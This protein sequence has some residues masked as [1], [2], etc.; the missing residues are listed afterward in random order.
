MMQYF[1]ADV[2]GAFLCLL[3]LGIKNK[4]RAV[5]VETLLEL[6]TFHDL[7]SNID[8][9]R[10][11]FRFLPLASRRFVSTLEQNGGTPGDGSWEHLVPSSKGNPLGMTFT[12]D[13]PM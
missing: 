4:T 9:S 7:P 1:L 13:I 8:I 10:R 12:M 6:L 5:L 3:P 11:W 2:A